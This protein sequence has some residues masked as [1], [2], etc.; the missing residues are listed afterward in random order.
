MPEAFLFAAN[1]RLQPDRL[2]FTYAGDHPLCTMQALPI[3]ADAEGL[4][5]VT[6]WDINCAN[7]AHHSI[8]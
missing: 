6:L 7:T 4:Y 1:Y 8:A 2:G 3:I 5:V